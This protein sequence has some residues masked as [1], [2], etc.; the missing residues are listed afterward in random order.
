LRRYRPQSKTA[1][2]SP[3]INGA[4]AEEASP[5]PRI[6]AAI[7]IVLLLTS[8]SLAQSYCQQVRQAVAT[9]GYVAAK[10]HAMT[11]ATAKRVFWRTQRARESQDVCQ[12]VAIAGR[13]EKHTHA[14]RP[15]IVEANLVVAGL[16]ELPH[17]LARLS[18]T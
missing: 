1:A 2:A 9:Y 3:G 15:Q 7:G 13:A 8:P 14:Q 16:D 18:V 5:M 17:A 12:I 11:A 6:V 4:M 10:R